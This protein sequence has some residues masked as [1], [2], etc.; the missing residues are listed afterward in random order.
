[1]IDIF[2]QDVSQRIAQVFGAKT[3]NVLFPAFPYARDDKLDNMGTKEH[4]KRKPNAA[5][6]IVQDCVTQNINHVITHD[7]HNLA[8]ISVP[9]MIGWK[10][11]FISTAYWR[12]IEEVIKKAWI[13]QE[14]TVLSGTDE[15]ALRKIVAVCKD[16]KLNN[17]TTLKAKD[18]SQA[19]A[20][21]DIQVYGEC[22]DKDV[23]LYDDILDTGGTLLTC[24]RKIHKKANLAASI[25]LSVTD[26]SMATVSNNC[27]KHTKHDYSRNCILPTQYSEHNLKRSSKKTTTLHS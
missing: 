9:H 27:S 26:Y 8:T 10:T 4:M 5:S 24:L 23:I 15:W 12:M 16:L 18:Y 20:V 21:E 7:I 13:I 22:T 6:M 25:S 14:N 11:K 19:Q 1:M 3:T 17:L 2:I